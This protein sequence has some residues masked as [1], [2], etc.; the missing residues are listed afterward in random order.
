LP[1]KILEK[2]APIIAE[3]QPYVCNTQ[4]L[5]NDYYN[6]GKKILLEGSQGSWLDIDHGNYPYVTSSSATIGG[7]VTGTGLSPNKITDVVLVTKGY[8]T[9]VGSG[10]MPTKLT[11]SVG[12]YIRNQGQEFGSVTGR[13]RDVGWLDLPL[14]KYA[15][16]INGA[17]ELFLS[18]IDVLSGLPEIKVCYT[19][20]Y[21]VN[22][23]NN[24]DEFSYVHNLDKVIPQYKTFAGWEE[25]ISGIRLYKDLP[26]N[27]RKYIEYIED[28]LE[29]P[30]KIVSVGPDR[31]ATIER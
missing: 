19:Y 12:E 11:D 29:V 18:K 25:D 27:A 3:I 28:Y 23:F 21:N 14:L 22:D 17:T 31:E 13:P 5:L 15:C 9:R 16:I 10:D 6:D 1:T 2:L 20:N 8:L 26:E 4:M 30:I 7:A 24:L